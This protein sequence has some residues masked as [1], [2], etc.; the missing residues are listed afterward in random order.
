MSLR[1]CARCKCTFYASAEAQRRHWPLHKRSCRPVTVAERGAVAAMDLATCCLALRRDLEAGGTA[2]TVPLLAREEVR[3]RRHLALPRRD[4]APVEE[5]TPRAVPEV[6]V[7][8]GPDVL[9]ARVTELRRAHP[10]RHLVA[11]LGLH[12]PGAARRTPRA[13]AIDVPRRHRVQC[14][15]RNSRGGPAYTRSDGV[16]RSLVAH[17]L[18]ERGA[19]G[20]NPATPTR[21]QA[22]SAI[23]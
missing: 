15:A 19:V 11:P 22:R 8:D 7:P 2:C 3:V 13:L 4:R 21:S 14:A 17:S 20:S 18:W 9:A 12:H 1:R 6:I 23:L 16:W 10:A 5:R